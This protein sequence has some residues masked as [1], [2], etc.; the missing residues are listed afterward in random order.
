MQLHSASALQLLLQYQP[1]YFLQSLSR[2]HLGPLIHPRR[3]LPSQLRPPQSVLPLAPSALSV[4]QA[5]TGM[6]MGLR[7]MS[8]SCRPR[9]LIRVPKKALRARPARSPFVLMRLNWGQGPSLARQKVLL[10]Y[11]GYPLVLQ[12]L[13]YSHAPWTGHRMQLLLI[14]P[15]RMQAQSVV[16]RKLLQAQPVRQ[17]RRKRQYLP[18]CQ[19][20]SLT[21]RRIAQAQKCCLDQQHQRGHFWSNWAVTKKVS[22]SSMLRAAKMMLWA[23]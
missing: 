22:L 21:R 20:G 4:Q 9:M 14:N 5:Q 11:S 17:N 16:L 7:R 23:G 13:R 6:E 19:A 1:A 12:C 10:A 18:R 2:L 15:F 3:A 8:L